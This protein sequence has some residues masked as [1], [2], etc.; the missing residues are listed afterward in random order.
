MYAYVLHPWISGC[1]GSQGVLSGIPQ[2]KHLS[3]GGS[4]TEDDSNFVGVKFKLHLRRLQNGSISQNRKKHLA[5]LGFT[6][7]CA[8]AKGM[9]VPEKGYD[10]CTNSCLGA[11]E[12]LGT[13]RKC[14]SMT[15]HADTKRLRGLGAEMHSL[16]YESEKE[17]KTCHG[18]ASLPCL[19]VI[20]RLVTQT[21]EPLQSS[22]SPSSNH[23]SLATSDTNKQGQRMSPV[24]QAEIAAYKLTMRHVEYLDDIGCL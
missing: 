9:E 17:K 7:P 4:L 23:D 18:R 20:S 24:L 13:S 21:T 8:S 11:D 15:S 5:L 1:V 3:V 14:T 6:G 16:E 12:S 22:I 19:V 2:L 10:W